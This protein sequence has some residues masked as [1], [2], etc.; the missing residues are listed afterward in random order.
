MNTRIARGPR[1]MPMGGITIHPRL[2]V[3]H[4]DVFDDAG[5]RQKTERH[6]RV[7]VEQQRRDGWLRFLA[8]YFTSGRWK[9]RYEAE[10]YSRVQI[11]DYP[12]SAREWALEYYAGKLTGETSTLY[13]PR[14]SPIRPPP[15]AFVLAE[16]RRHLPEAA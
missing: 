7:H 6:E 10:A 1:W 5:R 14:W 16:L 11:A 4:P 2:V 12:P 8:R 9:V 3:L 13:F 15:R